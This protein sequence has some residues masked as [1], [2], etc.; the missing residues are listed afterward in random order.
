MRTLLDRLFRD[1]GNVYAKRRA[2]WIVV[3]IALALGGFLV[4]APA[5]QD[6]QLNHI[7]G[8][9]LVAFGGLAFLYALICEILAVREGHLLP[10]QW[11]RQEEERRVRE[12]AEQA[13]KMQAIYGALNAG[14]SPDR[15]W[16]H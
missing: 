15:S 12:G 3:V 11:D 14:G 7:A 16:S 2:R 10:E 4:L 5:G 6:E 9:I 1:R 13:A 8:V